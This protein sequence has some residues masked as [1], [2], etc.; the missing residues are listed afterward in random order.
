[1]SE[2]EHLRKEL[3]LTSLFYLSFG[4]IIGVGWITVMGSWLTDAGPI[5]AIGAFIVGAFVVSLIGLCYAEIGA[6]YPV[7]GGEVAYAYRMYGSPV[8]FLCGWLLALNYIALLGFEAISVGWVLSA[9]FPGIE[10]P[11]IYTVLGSDVRLFGVLIGLGVMAALTA[12]QYASVRSVDRFQSM[13][14]IGLLGAA[15][16]FVAA[17]LGLG[18]TGNLKPYVAETAEG[19]VN[20]AGIAALLATTFFW[21]AGFDVIPQ[22]MGERKEGAPLHLLQW[23]MLSSI[24]MALVFYVLV[25]LAT[26]MAAPR[27]VVLS[28]DLPVAAAF[29]AVL[30]SKLIANLVLFAGLMGLLTTWNACFL[31]ATRLLFSLGRAHFIPH[32]FAQVSVRHGTPVYAIVFAAI[33]GS[34]LSLLGR[35]AI[36][37]IVNVSAISMAFVLLL[38]TLGVAKLRRTAPDHPRPY[39]TPFGLT[40]PYAAAAGSAIILAIGFWG[41]LDFSNGVAFEW[42]IL[43]GW[44]AIGALFWVYASGM[45][46]KVDEKERTYLILDE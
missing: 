45:R 14:T 42:Y 38:I 11:V 5:G 26:S 4:T 9:I 31:A 19:G 13:L 37:V 46:R 8:A 40:I 22:A 24:G 33:I 21:F 16:I 35:N 17:G 6:M 27:D 7:S 34:L 30:G 39:K 2:R 29:E 32:R 15:G 36:G 20:I 3:S 1:M 25:I 23:V 41:L 18:D 44:L 12:I 28:A 43:G 10:G